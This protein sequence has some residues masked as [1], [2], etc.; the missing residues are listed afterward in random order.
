M[1]YIVYEIIRKNFDE[2]SQYTNYK[3]LLEEVDGDSRFSDK[4]D[5]LLRIDELREKNTKFTILEVYGD[6]EN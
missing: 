2:Y 6:I 3:D 5:A 4:M 1:K